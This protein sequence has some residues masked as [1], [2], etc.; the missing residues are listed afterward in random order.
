[1][2]R[3][4][5]Q[6]LLEFGSGERNI[7]TRQVILCQE[8]MV[9]LREGAFTMDDRKGNFVV[10]LNCVVHSLLATYCKPQ[11]PQREGV[12]SGASA[13]LSRYMYLGT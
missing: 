11:E 12:E 8:Y 6:A 2:A 4:T 7:W 1:M 3:I 13:N 9:L 10:V 5:A